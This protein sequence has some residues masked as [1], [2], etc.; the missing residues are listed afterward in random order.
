MEMS[1][2]RSLFLWFISPWKY[3]TPHDNFQ[4]TSCVT[5]FTLSFLVSIKNTKLWS[6]HQRSGIKFFE[7]HIFQKCKKI[8]QHQVLFSYTKISI[9]FSKHTKSLAL[10]FFIHHFLSRWSSFPLSLLKQSTAASQWPQPLPLYHT[11]TPFQA[12]GP[13]SSF[14]NSWE[15][16][17]SRTKI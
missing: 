10:Q 12:L 7:C 8:W 4:P 11:R 9:F 3:T 2:V 13:A 15:L 6:V 5:N 1:W 14:G 17:L 16:F